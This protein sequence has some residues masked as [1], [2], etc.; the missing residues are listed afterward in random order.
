MSTVKVTVEAERDIFVPEGD[1]PEQTAATLLA[2]AEAAGLPARVV[3]VAPQPGGFTVPASLLADG[4]GG[5]LV[6]LF[7]WVESSPLQVD[8]ESQSTGTVVSTDWD[9][10]DGTTSTEPA[11][12]NYYEAAGTYSAVLTVTD[13]TGATASSTQDVIVADAPPQE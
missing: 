10:G 2:L 9:F 13:L 7:T 6:S 1:D 12:T 5:E 11:P 3:R 8:F 4:S